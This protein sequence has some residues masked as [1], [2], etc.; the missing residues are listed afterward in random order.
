[1]THDQHF[2]QLHVSENVTS[3]TDQ[4][5]GASEKVKHW[6]IIRKFSVIFKLATF[7]GKVYFSYN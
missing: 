2:V 5:A 4:A 6:D 7:K 3:T 1:M